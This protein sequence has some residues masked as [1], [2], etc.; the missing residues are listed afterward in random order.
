MIH[1][2]LGGSARL[3]LAFELSDLTR[4]LALAGLKARFPSMAR[5]ELMRELLRSVLPV[6]ARPAR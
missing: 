6:D 2:Q 1:R 4:D 5:A 3:A